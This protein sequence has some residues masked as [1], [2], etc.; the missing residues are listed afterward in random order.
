MALISNLRDMPGLPASA[1]PSGRSVSAVSGKEEHC[2]VLCD[3]GPWR[4]GT[5]GSEVAVVTQSC[6]WPLAAHMEES[7][8]PSAPNLAPVQLVYKKHSTKDAKIAHLDEKT[9][10]LKIEPFPQSD[11]TAEP[12]IDSLIHLAT[13]MTTNVRNRAGNEFTLVLKYRLTADSATQKDTWL[14]QLSALGIQV[15]ACLFDPSLPSLRVGVFLE[16][17]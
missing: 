1:H 6:F 3:W 10:V 15:R 4:P 13:P 11:D 7:Q 16:C 14:E 9:G 2:W 17:P 8:P 5:S 12:S